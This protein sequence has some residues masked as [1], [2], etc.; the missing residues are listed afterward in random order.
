MFRREDRGRSE[1]STHK[2]R[3]FIIRY[4]S[5]RGNESASSVCMREARVDGSSLQRDN[6][7][8]TGGASDRMRRAGNVKRG[9]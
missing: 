1:G 7:T 2:W 6:S 9:H 3:R 5:V 8:R 4:G